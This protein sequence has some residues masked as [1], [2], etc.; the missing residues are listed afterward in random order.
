MAGERTSAEEDRKLEDGNILAQAPPE[1]AP[2]TGG[3]LHPAFYI[4]LWITLSSSIILFNKWILTTA[5]FGAPP[6]CPFRPLL[7][8]ALF[9]DLM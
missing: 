5:G 4:A 3:G 9:A 2:S 1:D 7:P 8:W 6:R